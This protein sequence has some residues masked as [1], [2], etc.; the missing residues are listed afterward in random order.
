MRSLTGKELLKV[1]KYSITELGN[2]LLEL[3]VVPGEV[4][5]PRYLLYSWRPIVFQDDILELQVDFENPSHISVFEDAEY[6]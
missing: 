5:D 4:S 1:M 6:L 2:P 3:I